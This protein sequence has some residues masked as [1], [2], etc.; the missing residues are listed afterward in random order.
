[1]A[2]AEPTISVI[3]PARDAADHI[4][5][6]VSAALDQAREV[7]SDMEIIVVDDGS[8]DDTAAT[9][10]SAGARVLGL[11]GGPGNPGMARNRGAAAATGGLLIFLDADCVPAAGWLKAILAAH[12]GG[13][14]CVGGSLGQPPGLSATARWDYHFSSYHVHPR[15]P[16]AQV[17]NHT[18]ANLSI[19][20]ELFL[21]TDGFS[22]RLPVANGHEELAWQAQLADMG[23][24]IYFE[25]EAM[26]RH[27]N[28]PGLGNLFRRTYRWGYSAL[29]AKVESPA[30]R[31]AWQYRYPRLL[32]LAAFPLAPLHAAYIVGC[33]LRVGVLEPALVIP[34]LL[35][36]RFVYAAGTVAGGFRWL[37][38]RSPRSL[39]TPNLA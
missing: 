12:A 17:T 15:R 28:R 32:L 29:Q 39:T 4:G 30:A 19:G 10:H 18:P 13:Q 25:P 24:A 8:S 27:W 35:A 37:R 9:A 2:A 3:I 21:R 14:G 34:L 38:E 33:W 6:A 7:S 26:A 23:E 11:P 20:R 16:R 5:R 36:A 31:A 22:E 1:M